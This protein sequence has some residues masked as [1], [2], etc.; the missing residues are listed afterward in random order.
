M[1]NTLA[2]VSQNGVFFLHQ[3]QPQAASSMLSASQHIHITNG[4]TELFQDPSPT[5]LE[6]RMDVEKPQ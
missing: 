1:A 2:S 6:T 3:K 4:S 5:I